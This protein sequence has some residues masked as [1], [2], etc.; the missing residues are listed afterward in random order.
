[1]T[2]HAGEESTPTLG[3]SARSE[4]AT[5]NRPR[6]RPRDDEAEM[7][8][9][10]E[11]SDV[12]SLGEITERI[13][14]EIRARPITAIAVAFGAGVAASYALTS[15]VARVALLAAGG[16][17][18]KQILGPRLI[19]VLREESDRLLETEAVDA[20]RTSRG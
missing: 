1:M 3:E 10:E 7:D 16:L 6:R 14:D 20:R 19:E 9:M 12:V 2:S 5:S 17:A 15:K 8:A 18:A 4:P 11:S 13:E